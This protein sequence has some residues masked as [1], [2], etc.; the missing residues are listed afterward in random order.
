[1]KKSVIFALMSLLLCSCNRSGYVESSVRD[2]G[3]LSDGTPVKLY[4]ITNASGSSVSFTDYGLRIVSVMVPDK[5]GTLDDVIVGFG[6]LESFEL[7][8]DRF[9]GCVLG[10]YANRI[11]HSS[12]TL[13]GSTYELTSNECRE[14][15]P[16]QL[17]G[18]PEGFDCFV[19]E[20]QSVTDSSVCFHRI[21]P[22]G[23]QGYPGNL[24][25][26]VTYTWTDDS[27]LRLEYEA[28]TDKPTVV[29]LSNHTYFNPRGADG[30]YVMS[31]HLWVDADSCILNN[32]RYIPEQVVAVEGTAM[33]FRVRRRMDYLMEEEL[34]LR[35][36][37]G[38]WLVSSWDG[39]LRKVADLYDPNTGRGIETWTTEPNVL[40]FAARSWKGK[41]AGK[42]G[43][44]DKY[45]GMLFETLHPADAPNQSRFPST[46][47]RPGERYYSCTEYKFYASDIEGAVT[48]R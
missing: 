31:C 24:D 16:N 15:I 43:P 37:V 28:V 21:S 33:D 38:S 32:G 13:D 40:T 18:G 39:S 25:C 8:G 14:N 19:W 23:E 4:T 34:G 46:V 41:R 5:N 45:A 2:F 30:E 29:N 12:F 48:I 35:V 22:D 47:L 1:M 7:S 42:R 26:R 44:L 17:H 9:I 6:D 36:P 10:R 3:T 27:V 11:S 20:T